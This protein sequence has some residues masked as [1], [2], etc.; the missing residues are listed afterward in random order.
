M[1]GVALSAEAAQNL[2]KAR[3]SMRRLVSPAPKPLERGEVLGVEA[4]SPSPAIGEPVPQGCA[5][6]AKGDLLPGNPFLVEQGH[7]EGLFAGPEAQV[8]QPA[9]VEEVHLVRPRHRDHAER[10]AELDAGAGFLERLAQR[11]LARGLVV[12]H[13]AGGQ[14]PVAVARLDGA[15]AEENFSFKFWNAAYDQLGVLV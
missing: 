5:D 13:E 7:L 3:R 10:R 2:M 1:A 8:Q 12:L 9:E 15:P 6:R 4:E 14:G 11:R